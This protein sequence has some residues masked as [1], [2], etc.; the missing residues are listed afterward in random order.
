MPNA[1]CRIGNT[2]LLIRHLAFGIRQSIMFSGKTGRTIMVLLSLRALFILLMAAIGYYFLK[3]QAGAQF[4]QIPD[5][6]MLMIMLCIGVFDVCI[7]ILSPRRK[8]AI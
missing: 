4:Y 3:E 5:W 7:D 6:L 8:L 1:K 2:R